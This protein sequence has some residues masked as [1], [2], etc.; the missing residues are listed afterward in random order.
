MRD[1]GTL[2][3]DYEPRITQIKLS[4]AP[5][6]QCTAGVLLYKFFPA[7]FLESIQDVFNHEE[8]EGREGFMQDWPGGRVHGEAY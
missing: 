8:H 3:C 2:S 1:V 7:V 5:V 6:K 4:R